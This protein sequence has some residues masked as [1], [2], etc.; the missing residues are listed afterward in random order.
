MID[1]F[2][3]S[4]NI[5]PRFR[6]NRSLLRIHPDGN[7]FGSLGCIAND[8]EGHRDLYDRLDEYIRE[9]KEM[10][11]HVRIREPGTE[12][13]NVDRYIRNHADLSS[14]PL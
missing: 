4:L 1:G 7:A 12:T 11:V 3:W 10:D 6:T 2:G 14:S 5:D 9:N 13:D 8:A